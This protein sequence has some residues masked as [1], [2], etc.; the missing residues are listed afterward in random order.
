M[1]RWLAVLSPVTMF[2][3]LRTASPL[4]GEVG[5]KVRVGGTVATGRL[6]E[7]VRRRDH[8]PAPAGQSAVDLPLA[9]RGRFG[10][11]QKPPLAAGGGA[12]AIGGRRFVG[13]NRWESEWAANGGDLLRILKAL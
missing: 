1:K 3:V 2:A 11:A 13:L 12:S 7:T 8:Y 5:P 10:V 6:P 4:E 9:T